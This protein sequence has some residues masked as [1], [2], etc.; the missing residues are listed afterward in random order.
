MRPRRSYRTTVW[1]FKPRAGTKGAWRCSVSAARPRSWLSRWLS[2]PPHRARERQVEP[3]L[4]S[5]AGDIEVA[6]QPGFLPVFA[7]GSVSLASIFAVRGLWAG[8]YLGTVTGLDTVGVGTSMGAGFVQAIAGEIVDRR[9]TA[10]GCDAASLDTVVSWSR[11]AWSE[12]ASTPRA[13]DAPPESDS[14]YR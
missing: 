2:S 12:R 6:R 9:T 1:A 3:F 8:P 7:L 4:R 10:P 13:R 11:R 5:F 14:V